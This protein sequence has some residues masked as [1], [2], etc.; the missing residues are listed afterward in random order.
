MRFWLGRWPEF[1]PGR[2]L[3]AIAQGHWTK[4]WACTPV[5]CLSC[6]RLMNNNSFCLRGTHW[7][8]RV[9]SG[10]PGLCSPSASWAW[11]WGAAHGPGESASLHPELQSP[12]AWG[13]PEAWHLNNWVITALLWAPCFPWGAPQAF[14]YQSQQP[15]REISIT[16]HTNEERGWSWW[17]GGRGWSHFSKGKLKA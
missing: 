16:P 9:C 11:P 3:A 1:W 5:Y 6:D 7:M 17:E 12:S 10:F 4:C 2:Q 14:L 15:S 13:Q 8:P